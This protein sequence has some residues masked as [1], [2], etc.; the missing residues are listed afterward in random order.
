MGSAHQA[1]AEAEIRGLAEGLRS[2][3]GISIDRNEDDRPD[4]HLYGL[5]AYIAA[6]NDVLELALFVPNDATLGADAYLGWKCKSTLLIVYFE[7]RMTNKGAGAQ[8]Y[9]MNGLL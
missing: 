4:G 6:V 2:E 3:L 5:E 9:A 7:S 8:G 1:A